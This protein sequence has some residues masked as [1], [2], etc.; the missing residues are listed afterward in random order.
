MP[1][2]WRRLRDHLDLSA[3]TVGGETIGEIVARWPAYMDDEVIRPLDRPIWPKEGIAILSGS[4][5]PQGAA[6]KLAAATPSLF[7]FEG[8]ALVF[9]SLDDLAKRIDDRALES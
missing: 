1:A 9:D 4:L 5:A 3:P 7:R 2:L 6:I 8:P